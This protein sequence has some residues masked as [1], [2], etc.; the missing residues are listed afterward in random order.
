VSVSDATIQVVS[1]TCSHCGHER[2]FARE[3]LIDRQLYELETRVCERCGKA[4]YVVVLSSHAGT[5]RLELEKFP[6]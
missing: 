6:H 2:Q 3:G 1:L 4:G 5:A